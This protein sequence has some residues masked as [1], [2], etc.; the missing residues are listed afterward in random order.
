M[1]LRHTGRKLN[2][3]EASVGSQHKRT[4]SQ[5]CDQSE[6]IIMWRGGLRFLPAGCDKGRKSKVANKMMQYS[7][8]I[9]VDDWWLRQFGGSIEVFRI[10]LEPEEVTVERDIQAFL[11][12]PSSTQILNN[13]CIQQRAFNRNVF[14]NTLNWIILISYAFAPFKCFVAQNINQVYKKIHSHM[15]IENINDRSWNWISP[16]QDD[17]GCFC[18]IL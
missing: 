13:S 5:T 18:F 11:I 10:L 14:L 12:L 4:R 9:C 15:P 7:S 2:Q 16:L 8:C 3:N 17:E 1:F 6:Q